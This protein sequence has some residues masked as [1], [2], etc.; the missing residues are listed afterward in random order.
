MLFHNM[1]K[2]TEGAMLPSLLFKR[3]SEQLECDN[4][5]RENFC[6]YICVSI[7]MYVCMYIYIY[8]YI[9]IYGND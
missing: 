1:R 2:P 6:V 9:Y 7:E 3:V 8:I 5:S 4:Y